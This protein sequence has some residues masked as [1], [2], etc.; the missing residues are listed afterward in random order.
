LEGRTTAEKQKTGCWA[1][2]Q[3][4]RGARTIENDPSAEGIKQFAKKVE[5]DAS[6]KREGEEGGSRRPCK[7]RDGASICGKIA[8]P[9]G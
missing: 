5:W 4:R 3:S 8:V 7:A 6:T 1:F 2:N 9:P